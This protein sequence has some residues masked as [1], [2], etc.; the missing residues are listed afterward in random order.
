VPCGVSPFDVYYYSAFEEKINRFLKKVERISGD[1]A[2]GWK[3]PQN[4]IL[5][6]L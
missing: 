3:Y 2:P 6:L 4:H 1:G 5:S